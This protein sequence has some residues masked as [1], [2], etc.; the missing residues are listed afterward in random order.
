VVSCLL[1]AA[2]AC[3]DNPDVAPGQ[4]P[5][6]HDAGP[7]A[8][9]A[10]VPDA[11]PGN[12]PPPVIVASN[13][14][15]ATFVDVGSPPS[16]Q[17]VLVNSNLVQEP[18]GTQ[19]LQ[20]WFGEVKNVGST[21]ACFAQIDIRFLAASGT[22]FAAFEAFADAEPWSAGISVTIACIPAGQSG[23]LWS[24]DL[25]AASVPLSSV[26]KV[27]FVLEHSEAGAPTPAPNTPAVVSQTTS[28]FGGIGVTGTIT[29]RTSPIYDTGLDLFPRDTS[30][31]LF[32]ILFATDLDTLRPG[33]VFPFTTFSATDTF[34]QYRVFAS[35]IDGVRP[36][37]AI[38]AVTRTAE[39]TAIE[40]R[41][42]RFR[43][44]R[45]DARAALAAS[46]ARPSRL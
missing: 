27:S 36:P 35:F 3:G 39:Q 12:P 29:G 2:P 10:P 17:L 31:L 11:A 32:D 40:T 38:A 16:T 8:P 28:V 19:V 4:N 14:P 26:A 23:V 22:Q 41:A 42:A 24:A 34:S 43:Q 21:P 37:T 18:S 44:H 20:K 9:D 5:P 30:G 7:P 15:N 33:D 25:V 13:T 46:G 6:A 45:K 1:L